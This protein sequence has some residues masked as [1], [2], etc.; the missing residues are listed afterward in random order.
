MQDLY[1]LVTDR[2]VAALAA[3]TPPWVRPRNADTDLVP[4]NAETRRLYRRAHSAAY[5]GRS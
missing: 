3:G 4:M 5:S 1:Q 2:I